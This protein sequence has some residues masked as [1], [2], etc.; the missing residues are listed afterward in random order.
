MLRKVRAFY[1]PWF[2]VPFLLWM[3]AGAILLIIY[4]RDILFRTV[5]L[6]HTSFLDSAMLFLT[7]FGD[8]VGI[9]PI[10]LLLLVFQSCR[11]WWY[12]LAAIICNGVPAL[13]VQVLKWIF[14][15]PRP[16]QYYKA[17]ANWIHFNPAWGDHLYDHSFPS[18]HSAGVFSICCFLSMILPKGWGIAGIGLFIFGTLVA[19]S[20]MYL[21]AHF[22]LDIYVGSILG[23]VTTIFCFALMRH[24]S[25]RSFQITARTQE[26]HHPPLT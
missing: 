10:L 5:N 7:N 22:Y 13:L 3:M 21:A 18:G 4:D 16:F 23:T 9:V 14:D 17:D 1:N 11:N 20:R 12:I 6:H 2:I 8:A 15:A 25:K 24:W 26:R 19:Y